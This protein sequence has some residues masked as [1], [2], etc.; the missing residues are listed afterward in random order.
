MAYR[1]RSLTGVSALQ[2]VV[3]ICALV[4]FAGCGGRPYIHAPL[5]ST[6]LRSRATVQGDDAVRVSAAVPGAEETESLFGMSLYEQGVQPVWLEI[7]NKTNIRLRYAH[8][9]TDRE[10]FSPLEV[11]YKNRKGLSD[12]G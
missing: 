11:A 7:E 8:T 3:A 2:R 10:Y 9:G 4:V 5:E 12:E 1:Q 6:E